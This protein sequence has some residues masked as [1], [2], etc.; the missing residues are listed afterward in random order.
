MPR[1]VRR[2]GKKN[3]RGKFRYRR[4]TM[5][6]RYKRSKR[7]RSTTCS[8]L[9][10]VW[11]HRRSIQNNMKLAGLVYDV[12]KHFGSLSTMDSLKQKS[13]VEVVSAPKEPTKTAVVEALE[14]AASVRPPKRL[15]L[16]KAE[17]KF[18]VSMMEKHGSDYISVLLFC[19]SRSC[20][21]IPV[22]QAMARD[23]QN[24]FQLTPSKLR[25]RAKASLTTGSSIGDDM[26]VS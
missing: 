3:K 16:S 12:N 5:K 8:E 11:D 19:F 7:A 14:K 2:G 23:P 18:I 20:S 1:S 25:H 13:S 24:V 6:A 15:R 21:C 10:A 9:N 4:N 17:L 22:F 26:D